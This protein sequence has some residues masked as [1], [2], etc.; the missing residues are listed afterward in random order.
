MS[1]SPVVLNKSIAIM[2]LKFWISLQAYMILITPVLPLTEERRGRAAAV[3]TH[4]NLDK[5]CNVLLSHAY[6]SRDQQTRA[7]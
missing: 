6:G 5:T 3:S 4:T 7:V 1:V 2:Y